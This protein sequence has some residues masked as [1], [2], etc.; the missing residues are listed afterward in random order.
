ML[1]QMMSKMSWNR[2]FHLRLI[3]HWL[4]EF[5]SFY[6]K[7][8]QKTYRLKEEIRHLRISSFVLSTDTNKDFYFRYSSRTSSSFSNF[9]IGGKENQCLLKRHLEYSIR[10]FGNLEVPKWW[11]GYM[12][13]T[14]IIKPSLL[15]L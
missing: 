5:Y 4:W 3:W 10:N 9:Y 1:N 8:Q 6:I 12:L 11:A 7:G 14:E 13:K 2:N 15:I